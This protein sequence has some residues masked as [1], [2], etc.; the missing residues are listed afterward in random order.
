MIHDCSE[1]N[2]SDIKPNKNLWWITAKWSL[3]FYTLTIFHLVLLQVSGQILES[4]DY[5]FV[6]G[7]LSQNEA[8]GRTFYFILILV[9]KIEPRNLIC[10]N[11]IR[12]V[13]IILAWT[14]TGFLLDIY[15]TACQK[16]GSNKWMFLPETIKGSIHLFW[17]RENDNLTKSDVQ[18]LFKEILTRLYGIIE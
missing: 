10:C 13:N 2:I 3:S 16:R 17:N 1:N 15:G 6:F 18:L 12:R 14:L 5:I 8:I 9:T 4:K 11:L 7:I